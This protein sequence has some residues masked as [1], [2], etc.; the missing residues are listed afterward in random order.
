MYC[1]SSPKAIHTHAFVLPPEGPLPPSQVSLPPDQGPRGMAP[2]AAG[3]P[4]HLR[5]PLG[6]RGR[7]PARHRDRRRAHH[8]GRRRRRRRR[9]RGRG[10]ARAAAEPGGAA[11]ARVL[12]GAGP[13]RLV[14]GP[15]AGPAARVG[16][17]VRPAARRRRGCRRRRRRF[18][19][20]SRSWGTEAGVPAA[21]GG[22]ARTREPGAP[23]PRPG[24]A[25]GRSVTE[26]PSLSKWTSIH[27]GATSIRKGATCWPRLQGHESHDRMGLDFTS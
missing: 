25:L 8:R 24:A 4:L 16:E 13:G 22:A 14:H 26:C 23:G 5:A 18:V 1:V 20:G 19:M 21:G 7:P 3:R 15:P 10:R 27:K 6:P 2:P 9:R 17:P 11:D 12:P